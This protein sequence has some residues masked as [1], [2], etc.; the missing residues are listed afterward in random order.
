M[1]RKNNKTAST[2]K[3][4]PA[5]RKDSLPTIITRDI[6]LLGNVVSDGTID[7]DG[8]IDGNI[9]CQTL[10]V[11]GHAMVN[12]EIIA[13]NVFVYGKIKG[14]IRA[15]HVVL[16]STCHI[17]GIILHQSISIEDGAFVDG[18]CKRTDKPEDES[19]EAFEDDDSKGQLKV[20]ENIRLIS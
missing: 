9:H 10:T 11:R 16:F 2:E 12:G 3:S 7:F 1:F 13:E 4:A 15:K 18:K 8:R 20:L 17:E 19:G 14:I 5:S 6:N